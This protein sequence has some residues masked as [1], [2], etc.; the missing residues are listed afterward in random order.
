MDL[1]QPPTRFQKNNEIISKSVEEVA[2]NVMV[3]A[4][5]EVIAENAGDQTIAVYF[6][7]MWQKR[8]HKSLNGVLTVT[9]MD[10]SKVLDAIFLSKHCSKK[11]YSAVNNVPR[12][13][14][15]LVCMEVAAAKQVF[16]RS[17]T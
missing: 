11:K 15:V 4:A 16:E 6:D 5:R 12:T 10:T 8:R 17:H 13:T 9:S 3:Q 1:P 7:G 2:E 14:R